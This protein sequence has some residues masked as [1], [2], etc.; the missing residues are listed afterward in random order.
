MKMLGKLGRLGLE[1]AQRYER[2]RPGELI[3]IDVKKPGQRHAAGTRT[4]AE[5]KTPR[6]A[7]RALERHLANA[8]H[9][10]LYQW[11]ENTLPSQIT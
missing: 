4:D 10:Q 5:G 1:P 2:A 3:H 8:L 11:A 7:R 6:E 9:R